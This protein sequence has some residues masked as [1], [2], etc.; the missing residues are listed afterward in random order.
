MAFFANSVV[1]EWRWMVR[2]TSAAS[3]RMRVCEENSFR[4]VGR[5]LLTSNINASHNFQA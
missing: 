5:Q 3:L 4:V 2:R 1:V